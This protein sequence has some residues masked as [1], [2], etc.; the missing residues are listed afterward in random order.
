MVTKNGKRFNMIMT[1]GK[2]IS[3]SITSSDESVLIKDLISHCSLENPLYHQLLRMGKSQALYACPKQFKYYRYEDAQHLSVFRGLAAWIEREAL[4]RG[5]YLEQRHETFRPPVRLHSTIRLRNYQQGIPERIVEKDNG[6]IRLDT[7]FGKTIVALKVAELLQTKTLIIVPRSDLLEQFSDETIKYFGFRPDR[8]GGATSI[9][10]ETIQTLQRKVKKNL[11]KHDEFGCVIVDEC[12]LSVPAKSRSVIMS[13]AP[14]YLYGMTATPRREDGQG[15]AIEF[16]YGPIVVDQNMERKS[17][18]VEIV[19]NGDRIDI[20]EYHEMIDLQ[21]KDDGRN[22]LILKHLEIEITSGRKILVLAKRIEHWEKLKELLG[23]IVQPDVQKGLYGVSG[24]DKGRK[25]RDLYEGLRK[26]EIPFSV[27]FGTFSLLSTGFDLPSLD[28]LLIA[29]DLKS[30]ILTQQSAGRIL[31]LFEGKQSP[32]I[33]DIVD[34]NNA[35][36]NRQAKKREKFYRENAWPIK[37]HYA[38]T[39]ES[40]RVAPLGRSGAD[41]S[42]QPL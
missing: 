37:I 7:G 4:R 25:R 29:G 42:W 10:V 13:F 3:L 33:I 34:K 1:V 35:I 22:N 8:Y 27:L 15:K 24:S 5:I 41:A 16:L 31:R 21:T 28:T 14:K 36:L 18:T 9:I 38:Q 6:I 19:Q 11:L 17:P 39:K 26:G 23:S 2:Y 40:R 32:K 20:A 30:S 12:H